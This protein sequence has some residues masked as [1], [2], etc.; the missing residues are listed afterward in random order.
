[1]KRL[2]LSLTAYFRVEVA[3]RLGGKK[4]DQS[5]AIEEAIKLLFKEKSGG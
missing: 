1:M 2:K 3:K 4:G 5:K